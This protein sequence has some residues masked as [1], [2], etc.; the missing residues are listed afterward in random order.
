MEKRILIID[1]DR[2]SVAPLQAELEREGYRVSLMEEGETELSQIVK[3][4]PD[5]VVY[6]AAPPDNTGLE[7]LASIRADLALRETP[8]LV[9]GACKNVDEMTMRYWEA[10]IDVYWPNS[11]MAEVT[12]F[13]NLIFENES[14]WQI[15]WKA[16]NVQ[17]VWEA[18]NLPEGEAN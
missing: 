7:L 16:Q 3:S 15:A 13:I 9:H 4:R 1:N 8:V 18:Q 17:T 2:T 6:K 11:S 14:E 5:A 12:Y 10:G